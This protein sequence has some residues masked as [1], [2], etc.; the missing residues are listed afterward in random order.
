MRAFL[1][2]KFHALRTTDNHWLRKT[3]G[4]LLVLGGMLGFL[5][6]LGYWMFPLGLALLAVDFPFARRLNRR[7]ILWWGRRVNGRVGAR[8]RTPNSPGTRSGP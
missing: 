3:V 8:R 1:A 2:H 6:V 7:L 5:P 4:G